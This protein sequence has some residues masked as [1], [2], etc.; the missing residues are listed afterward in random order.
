MRVLAVFL[1]LM[2]QTFLGATAFAEDA[3]DQTA[4]ITCDFTDG[5]EI[6]VQYN[7]SAMSE[8]DQP[9]NGRVWLPG[10]SPMTLFTQ[11]PLILNHV[12]L[13]VGAYSMYVIPNKKDWTLIVSKNVTNP[14]TYDEKQDLVRAPMEMGGVNSPPKRLQASFAHV[15]PRQCSIRLYY[16]S[17]GAFVEFSEK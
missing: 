1:V 13:A 16:E 6:T 12:E 11:V 7:N 8:K 4:T 14:K 3:T 5:N 10:G 9:R 17:N 2:S 15:A